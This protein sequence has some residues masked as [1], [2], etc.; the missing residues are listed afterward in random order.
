MDSDIAF[1][2]QTVV[3]EYMVIPALHVSWEGKKSP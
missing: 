2:P 3:M 1:F